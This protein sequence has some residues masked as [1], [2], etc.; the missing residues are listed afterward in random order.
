MRTI[1]IIQARL[2]SSRLPGKVLEVING[3]PMLQ[4]V[5]E[6]AAAIPGVDG[7]CLTIPDTDPS[8]A[9]YD[10]ANGHYVSTGPEHDVLRRYRIAAEITN[11][12]RI[13]RVTADCPLLDPAVAAQVIALHDSNLIVP[14]VS[15]VYPKRTWPDGLDVEVFTK[16][17][18]DNAGAMTFGRKVGTPNWAPREHPTL[19]MRSVYSPCLESKVDMGRLKWSVDTPEELDFV[20]EV[21]SRL[22][23]GSYRMADTMEAIRAVGLWL[24]QPVSN[25]WQENNGCGM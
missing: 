6:R 11:A 7:V 20:R 4:H 8:K 12:D 17:A 21:M 13:V 22:P 24:R 19:A 16:M 23:S 1:V 15:N 25:D 9:L 2:G 3:K 18:L 5:L 10:V 14:Y